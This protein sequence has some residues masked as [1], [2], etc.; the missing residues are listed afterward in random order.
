MKASI[1]IAV[2]IVL[3]TAVH[4]RAAGRPF[5][6]PDWH[7][8]VP[9]IH[10]GGWCHLE[11]CIFREAGGKPPR[12]AWFTTSMQVDAGTGA[13]FGLSEVTLVPGK[14]SI[15]LAKFAQMVRNGNRIS[16]SGVLRA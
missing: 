10:V 9:V 6:P 15:D 12:M 7:P 16:A 4:A 1:T 2:L 11:G 13:H 3:V 14:L 5:T 8:P